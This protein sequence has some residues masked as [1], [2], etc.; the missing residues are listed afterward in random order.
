[1]STHDTD[2]T[3]DDY[4]YAEAFGRED[5][6]DPL[7]KHDETFKRLPCPFDKFLEDYIRASDRS[8]KTKECYERHIRFWKEYMDEYDRHPACP[9]EKHVKD[10]A[11]WLR[12][13]GTGEKN[14]NRS[15]KFKYQHVGAAFKWMGRRDDLPHNADPETNV[16]TKTRSEIDL[17]RKPTPDPPRM[18]KEKLREHIEQVTHLR[19]RAIMMTQVKLGMRAGEVANIRLEDVNIDHPGIREHYPEMG[20]QDA[21]QDRPN[22]IH[23]PSRATREGNKSYRTR[24]LPLDSEL[25]R[26]LLRYL[27]IRPE[28]DEGWLFLTHNTHGKIRP[29]DCNRIWR[30]AFEEFEVPPHRREITSHFGRHFF[31]TYWEIHQDIPTAFVHY[32]RGDDVTIDGDEDVSLN[33]YLHTYYEDIED[34]YRKQV[35]RFGL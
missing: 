28:N 10:W 12:N 27:L 29:Q 1:M 6:I 2:D 34:V 35:F 32:M 30:A 20:E 8:D 5:K 16:F 26:T 7:A 11:R 18:S 19:D 24:V 9:N 14:S 13:G 31:T 25:R 3:D 22:S 23:I 33:Y 4:V 17:T 21:V 15:I